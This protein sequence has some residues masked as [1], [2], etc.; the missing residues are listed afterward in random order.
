MRE[1]EF[2]PRKDVSVA[3]IINLQSLA[4]CTRIGPYSGKCEAGKINVGREQGYDM[5]LLFQHETLDIFSISS[6]ST[7]EA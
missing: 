2:K 1:F 6:S 4:T 3:R 7:K 5:M